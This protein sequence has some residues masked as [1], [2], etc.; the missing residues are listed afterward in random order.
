MAQ[1]FY[2]LTGEADKFS[3]KLKKAQQESLT[4]RRQIHIPELRMHVFTKAN[5]TEEETRERYL[6]KTLQAKINK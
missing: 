4:G 6:N 1:K 5:E 2:A 3:P